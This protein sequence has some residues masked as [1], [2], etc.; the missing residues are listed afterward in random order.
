MLHP[1]LYEQV[2]N[3]ALTGELAEIPEARKSVAPIDKPPR[4]WRSIWQM[5]FKRAWITC[6]TTA[7]IFLPRSG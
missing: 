1:G 5:W 4:C 2:I 6:W 3:N 7:G